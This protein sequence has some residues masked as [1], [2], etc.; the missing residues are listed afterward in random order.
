MS[1]GTNGS[2]EYAQGGTEIA[3]GVALI[4][5]EYSDQAVK[6]DLN[7]ATPTRSQFNP[8]TDWLPHS[9]GFGNRFGFAGYLKPQ[10]HFTY[11]LLATGIEIT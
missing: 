6:I 1:G 9:P 5:T 10:E 4:F 11:S 3:P 2:T 8:Y 7:P